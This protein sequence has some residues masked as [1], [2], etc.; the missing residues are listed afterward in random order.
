MENQS[1]SEPIIIEHKPI[2]K[3]NAPSALVVPVCVE[4]TN[5]PEPNFNN[6]NYEPL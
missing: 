4:Q 5:D 1:P 3:Y 2:S 6:E